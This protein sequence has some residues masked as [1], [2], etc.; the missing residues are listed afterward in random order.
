MQ[1]AYD[2]QHC[3]YVFLV[4]LEKIESYF[5]LKLVNLCWL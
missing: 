5:Y 1:I 2:F 4:M 3:I